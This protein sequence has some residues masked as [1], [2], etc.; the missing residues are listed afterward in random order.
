MGSAGT[1]LQRFLSNDYDDKSSIP[2]EANLPNPRTVSNVVFKQGD[3]SVPNSKNASDM[4]WQFGQ[5]L[6]HD[7]DLSDAATP[8]EDLSITIPAGDNEFDPIQRMTKHSRCS[9]TNIF[10]ILQVFDNRLT[11]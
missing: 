3:V 11:S 7:L 1:P 8:H 10:W 4:I 2:R 9:G 6:D 5:F